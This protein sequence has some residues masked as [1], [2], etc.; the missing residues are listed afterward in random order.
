[1]NRASNCSFGQGGLANLHTLHAGVGV[2]DAEERA[3][4]N[5]T[6]HDLHPILMDAYGLTEPEITLI[7]TGGDG[8][9]TFKVTANEVSFIARIYGEQTRRHPDWARYELELLMHLAKSGISVAAPIAGRDGTWMQMLPMEGALPT[10]TALFTFAEGGVEWPTTPHRA[11]LLGVS[12]AQLHLA[13]DRMRS[14]AAPRRFDAERLLTAPLNRMRAYLNDSDPK[15]AEAWQ[16]LT[17]T[18]TRAAALFAAIP[19]SGGAIGPIHGDL[20]Q[21]NCHF[22]T[23]GD[24][25]QLTFFDFSNAGFGWRVYDL[26]G[27]LWPLRDNTIQDPAIKAACD[28]FLNGYRSVRPL[29]PEEENAILASVKARDF[30]ETG[31]W[32]EFGQNLDPTV[33]RKGLH[34]IADQFRRFPL[35]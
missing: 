32:L 14:E 19:H 2:L 15:D 3:M 35:L 9:Q 31:C 1:M 8:N 27:F 22:N 5:P 20:H 23:T 24:G 12:F 29:L 13:A 17:Q 30:W 4:N 10:P 25:D 28:A 21:G 18:A 16:I 26:S 33:V 7:R 34:S 6:V 11:H